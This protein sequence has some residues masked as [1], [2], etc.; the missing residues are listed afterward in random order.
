MLRMVKK[1]FPHNRFD[2]VAMAFTFIMI[3]VAYLHGLYNI[4]P[5]V[6]PVSGVSE[7][8]AAANR[9]SYN[10]HAIFITFLF[11]NAVGHL[12][13]TLFTNTSR[14]TKT[15]PPALGTARCARPA[16]CAETTTVT[17]LGGGIGYHNHRFFIS[18][19]VYVFI[20]AAYAAAMSAWVVSMVVGGFTWRLIPSLMFPVMAWVLGYLQVPF[21][22]TF[23]T[24]VAFMI[25]LGS[26]ALLGLQLVQIWNGQ[27]YYEYLRRGERVL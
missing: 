22:T 10:Q 26:G 13:Y 3:P 24:S 1:L 21:I 27:T 7:E 2:A 14:A 20:A 11:V 25:L 8:E 19:L 12:C 15:R 17:S 5:T 18:F 4:L 16:Y 6:Y 9:S 23:L